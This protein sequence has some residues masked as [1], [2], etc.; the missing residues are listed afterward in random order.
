MPHAISEN[1]LPRQRSNSANAG[2]CGSTKYLRAST[3]SKYSRVPTG[4]RECRTLQGRRSQYRF[5]SWTVAI[6]K[7]PVTPPA[8][9]G[10]REF[11]DP[12]KLSASS[13]SEVGG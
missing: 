2:I 12:W 9:G 5:T 3:S 8:G 6:S 11:E 1:L 13:S 7:P 4:L 10:R